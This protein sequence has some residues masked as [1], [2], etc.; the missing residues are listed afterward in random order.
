[1]CV[2]GHHWSWSLYGVCGHEVPAPWQVRTVKLVKV[3]LLVFSKSLLYTFFLAKWDLLDAINIKN[4]ITSG[5]FFWKNNKNNNTVRFWLKP[6]WHQKLLCAG[7]SLTWSN[8][9][10]L[11]RTLNI[12]KCAA[13]VFG[14]VRLVERGAP[15]SLPLMESGKVKLIM[16]CPVWVFFSI[17]ERFNE[18]HVRVVFSVFVSLSF[19]DTAR[20]SGDHSESRDPRPTWRFSSRRG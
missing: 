19:L 20:C 17:F 12:Y 11:I 2:S 9:Q 10:R 15:Q 14:R 7:K 8:S 6:H 5:G 18:K 4:N 16:R 1:M 13:C 3:N